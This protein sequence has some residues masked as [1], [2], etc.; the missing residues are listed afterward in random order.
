VDF[1]AIGARLGQLRVDWLLL[2]GA[3]AAVQFMPATLP[4]PRSPTSVKEDGAGNVLQQLK[5]PWRDG[6]TYLKMT[7][8]KF[9]QRLVVRPLRFAGLS[10]T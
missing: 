1:A 9:L 2:A 4:A 5:S 8:L 6:T 3:M 10:R 7:P